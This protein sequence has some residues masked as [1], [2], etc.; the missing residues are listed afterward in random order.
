MFVHHSHNERLR[1]TQKP[2]PKTRGN[3]VTFRYQ[4]DQV[5]WGWEEPVEMYIKSY[6][7]PQTKRWG[8]WSTHT[9]LGLTDGALWVCSPPVKP[10]D[11]QTGR[12]G[13]R[14]TYTTVELADQALWTN[15]PHVYNCGTYRPGTVGIW[16]TC[17]AVGLTDWALRAYGPHIQLWDLQTGGWRYM[18]HIYSCRTYRAGVEDIVS[19]S[20]TVEPK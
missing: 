17:K 12:W 20:K 11:L 8:V 9:T 7:T 14:S 3:R 16:S 2:F 15:G 5:G 19:A 4:A 10:S 6:S 13:I 1:I 18:N